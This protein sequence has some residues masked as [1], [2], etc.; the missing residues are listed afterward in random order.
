MTIPEAIIDPKNGAPLS[1]FTE[2]MKNEIRSF[3]RSITGIPEVFGYRYFKGD[4]DDRVEI[5]NDLPYDGT[6][7]APNGSKRKALLDKMR[8]YQCNHD[9]S[10]REWLQDDVSLKIGYSQS[11]LMNPLKLQMVRL[12]DLYYRSFDLDG[13]SYVLF[14]E[15]APEEILPFSMA[16]QWKKIDQCGYPR[17]RGIR[18]QIDGVW[19][20]LSFSGENPSA[21]ASLILFQQAAKNTNPNATVVPYFIYEAIAYLMV[22]ELGRH[23]V[24]VAYSGITNAGSSYAN[25]AVAGVT[26]VL[27]TP[28]GEVDVEYEEGKFTKQ[29]R[30]RFIEG[31]YG[32][33][34]NFLTGVY[35]IYDAELNVNKVYITRD[36]DKIN[37]SRN[38]SDY[39]HIGNTPA[40]NEWVKEFI[41]GSIIC[42]E[43]GGSSTTYKADYNY[44][45]NS[46]TTRVALV[47]GP[48]TNGGIAGLFCFASTYAASDA[49]VYVGASLVLPEITE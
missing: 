44:T 19:K 27:K 39:I 25:A 16:T 42:E 41:P 32:Q 48:S 45:S 12:P 6:P 4:S 43:L 31:V 35:Y 17:Y 47:G 1:E 14:C 2:S 15:Q 37:T 23:N 8:P 10:N 18:K 7:N 22:L 21:S 36:Y 28:S 5:V 3:L 11:D 13:Y 26:D 29:F 24:Q 38:V 46:A 20:L 49:A 40:V 34:W 30:W 9:A 33:I